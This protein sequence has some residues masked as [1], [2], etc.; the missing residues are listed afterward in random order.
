M[1][2]GE[3]VRRSTRTTTRKSS[4]GRV[5]IRNS[6]SPVVLTVTHSLS[7]TFNELRRTVPV[8]ISK[9][10]LRWYCSIVATMINR[11]ENERLY[12]IL[13]VFR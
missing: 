5:D 1:T 13:P 3:G 9:G 6:D 8:Q 12:G 4:F 2:L 10:E 11:Q 7:Q